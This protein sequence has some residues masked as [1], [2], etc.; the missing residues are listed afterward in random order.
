ML[1]PVS[2]GLRK[3]AEELIAMDDS[4]TKED[5]VLLNSRAPTLVKMVKEN[6]EDKNADPFKG[7]TDED[8][9]LLLAFVVYKRQNITT[10]P[11]DRP[12]DEDAAKILHEH[13]YALEGTKKE[14]KEA[15]ENLEEDLKKQLSKAGLPIP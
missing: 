1:Q 2:T 13:V 11:T 3:V 6:L 15:L 10:E 5:V 12:N 8:K 4:L 14:Q 9:R 7:L